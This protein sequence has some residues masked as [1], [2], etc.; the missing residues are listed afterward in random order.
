MPQDQV[1][2]VSRYVRHAEQQRTEHEQVH[3]KREGQARCER[4]VEQQQDRQALFA[5]GEQHAGPRA[6][7]Q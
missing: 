4:R 2:N 7:A 3:R 5:L 1:A 6:A